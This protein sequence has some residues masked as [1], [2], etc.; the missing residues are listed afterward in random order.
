MRRSGGTWI[1]KKLVLG[2]HLVAWI[3]L[4]KVET[5][6]WMVVRYVLEVTLSELGNDLDMGWRCERQESMSKT[7]GFCLE[8]YMKGGEGRWRK[9]R[10]VR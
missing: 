9:S 3:R 1:D 7:F 6:K 5:E 10:F 4:M 8:Q 2:L